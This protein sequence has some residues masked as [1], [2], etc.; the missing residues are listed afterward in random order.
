MDTIL[1]L[2]QYG[3]SPA[4]LVVEYP[5][6][7]LLGG[8]LDLVIDPPDG[9]VIEFKFPRDSRTGISPDTMTLGELVR[10][11]LRAAAVPAADHWV[12]QVLNRRLQRYLRNVYPR[13]QLRWQLAC[14]QTF[15]ILPADLSR[16]PATAVKAIGTILVTEPVAAQ[17]VSAESIDGGLGLFAYQIGATGPFTAPV[18]P[19]PRPAPPVDTGASDPGTRAGARAEILAA[20]VAVTTRAGHPAFTMID[21]LAEMHRLGT[22]YADSTIRTMISSHICADTNGPG[23]AAYADLKRIDRGTYRLRGP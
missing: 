20:A 7:E 6:A 16:L 1:T 14:G 23:I 11:F 18:P 15:Q 2:G 13:H 12:V 17:C 3:V 8:K 9:T 22:G 10:D 21:I 5:A 19:T 4:R